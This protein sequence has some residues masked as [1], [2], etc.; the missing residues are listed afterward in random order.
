MKFAPSKLNDPIC[1]VI[2]RREAPNREP[3]ARHGANSY[4]NLRFQPFQ[5]IFY[6]TPSP[7]DH[8]KGPWECD[9]VRGRRPLGFFFPFS[10]FLLALFS[11][12]R[13]ARARKN[14]RI[15]SDTLGPGE[16]ENYRPSHLAG[17]GQALP[18]AQCRW[19]PGH[20]GPLRL[21]H[22]HQH[23]SQKGREAEDRKKKNGG[24][25]RS[26]RPSGLPACRPN[27]PFLYGITTTTG[28]NNKGREKDRGALGLSSSRERLPR[29]H[30]LARCRYRQH[31]HRH[32][33][34]DAVPATPH[35]RGTGR[36]AGPLPDPSSAATLHLHVR[37]HKEANFR[38]LRVRARGGGKVAPTNLLLFCILRMYV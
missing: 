4:Q 24:E 29:Q 7:A 31:N 17:P 12:L 13:G 2:Q 35:R 26:T 6:L 27:H 14:I 8:W 22:S 38:I 16:I 19:R 36:Q 5:N 28:Q 25:K 20:K 37:H 15:C 18:R 30:R 11:Q 32:S 1:I 10:L 34:V 3:R 9:D 23:G 21:H 33:F